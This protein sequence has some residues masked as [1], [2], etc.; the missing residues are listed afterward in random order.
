MKKLQ[1]K[2]YTKAKKL[3]CDWNDKKKQLVYFSM[4]KFYVR[5]G[6]V[7]EKTHEILSFKQS[8]RLEN[9]IIFNTQ[10]QNRAENDFEKDF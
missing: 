8:K 6:M 7:V 4:L 5:H 9:Y 3:K 2:N 1:P 10:K